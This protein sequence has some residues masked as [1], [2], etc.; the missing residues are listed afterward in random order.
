MEYRGVLKMSRRSTVL[1]K[2]VSELS[3]CIDRSQLPPCLGGYFMYC[4]PSWVAF[5]KEI[6]LFLQ[7][8]PVGGCQ[9]LPDCISTLQSISRLPIPDDL[10]LLTDFC[11][12]TD[13][14]PAAQ[15]V[16]RQ[17]CNPLTPW[18]LGLDA[19]QVRCEHVVS[20]LRF[21]EQDPCYLAMAGTALFTHTARDMLHNYS[22]IT[23]AVAK[24]ELLWQQAFSRAHVRL[25]LLQLQV[26]ALKMRDQMEEL[27]TERVQTYGVEAAEDEEKARA[28][29]A[30]FEVSVYTPAV[31]REPLLLLLL[32]LLLLDLVRSSGDVLHTLAE[33]VSADGGGPAQEPWVEEVEALAQKLLS[34]VEFLHRTLGAQCDFHHCY[35][36]ANRWYSLVLC[37][38]F[39]QGL[40]AGLKEESTTCQVLPD[41]RP[42]WRKPLA[43]FL[44]RN[45]P[46]ALEE[47]VALV[48]LASVQTQPRLQRAGRQVAQRC[49][50]LRKLLISQDAVAFS[51][52][53]M[54]L[55]WQYDLLRSSHVGPPQAQPPA[56]V[57]P[58]KSSEQLER[59]PSPYPSP[60]PRSAAESRCS[61][62]GP[63]PGHWRSQQ[64]VLLAMPPPTEGKPSSLSSFDSGFD[65]AGCSPL[66]V[67]G[68]SV[69]GG[70]REGW[71][72]QSV[73]SGSRESFGPPTRSPQ[74]H[75]D[76]LSVASDSEDLR[77]AFN[78]GSAGN[79][80]RASIQIVPKI[81]L[82]SLNFEI[83]V[84]RSATPPQ[85]PWLSLPV[86]DL[87]KSYTVTI[88]PNTPEPRL[89][90][91]HSSGS[92]DQP[93][94]TEAPAST[95]SDG[96]PHMEDWAPQSPP[97]LRDP[98]LSPIQGL[99]S[100]TITD[101]KDKSDCTTEGNP[102]LIWD[103][104][105]LHDQ[106][107][108][109][110][111]HHNDLEET[112]SG[113]LDVSM[114]DWD[115]K[116]QEDLRDVEEILER[117]DG[118]LTMSASELAEAGV[119][120]NLEP[121]QTPTPSTGTDP[122]VD[123]VYRAEDT[124]PAVFD[125]PAD[126][127]SLLPEL[128]NI[129]IL[130]ELILEENLKIRAL[131]RQEKTLAEEEKA[132]ASLQEKEKLSESDGSPVASEERQA[133]RHELQKEKME[134][135]RMEKS[136]R[137]ELDGGW[138]VRR[139]AIRIRKVVKCSALGKF[140]ALN[141]EDQEL[142]NELLSGSRRRSQKVLHQTLEEPHEEEW[143]ETETDA[144]PG[145]SD[146]TRSK[147]E[148]SLTPEK[149][150]DDGAFDPGG[151][152]L[153]PPPPPPPVPKPRMLCPENM[154]VS[155]ENTGLSPENTGL[156]S[157]NTGISPENMGISPEN[158]RLSLETQE[159][160]CSVEP[161]SEPSPPTQFHPPPCDPPPEAPP[162]K[163]RERESKSSADGDLLVCSTAVDHGSN[164]NNNNNA[165]AED[166][167]VFYREFPV[168]STEETTTTENA[169]MAPAWNGPSQDDSRPSLDESQTLVETSSSDP[170]SP[171]QEASDEPMASDPGERSYHREDLADGFQCYSTARISRTISPALQ[172][173]GTR[174]DFSEIS[175]FKTPIILDTGSGVMKAGFSDQE[176]PS[177]IFPTIIGL[178]KYEE[179]M[180][181][182]AQQEAYIGH[183]AQQMRGVLALRYPMKNG[184]I[185]NWDDMEKLLGVD[186]EDHPV[187]LTEAPMNPAESRARAVEVLFDRFGVPFV[188][189]A[190]QPVL[191]LYAAGRCTGV[192]FDSGDG[193]SH[194]VPVFEGY[195]L[196]HAIQ[197]FPLAGHDVTLHLRKEQ[198]VCLRT[199][200]ELEIVRE[201][202]ERCCRVALDYEAE[203]TSSTTGGAAGEMSYTLPDGQV[204]CLASE[205][206]R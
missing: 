108:P 121:C 24:V 138:R 20:K 63:G 101:G 117:A 86:D 115:L 59:N 166:S 43:A 145:G 132:R 14:L 143:L 164:N 65:G 64:Q 94:Q 174:D 90:R 36:K 184:V 194:S 88:T 12:T 130:D 182:S 4:H 93:T 33:T 176:L 2:D 99:L 110:Q 149:R 92:R 98:G 82:D 17:P 177:V 73:L 139:Q 34:R 48:Q 192:V 7:A 161:R 125:S 134:V 122:L 137:R 61:P 105:D 55:Q 116:V 172:P 38:N 196:P 133:F 31:V 157:E 10:R 197:R 191:A 69:S 200:A 102:T 162:P 60:R 135:E 96:G 103:S 58:D 169:T 89:S 156:S 54:A 100:S 39:L 112:S 195:S 188:Y 56:A 72:G 140:G 74:T 81:K 146:I 160:P 203:L 49:M 190:V 167:P 158:T 109:D 47:L 87:E 22:R 187:M 91:N 127:G 119:S 26:E 199:S 51:D 21:P 204:L 136:L 42:P 147:P 84:Q 52:L 131:Q 202:K 44:R 32:L 114:L 128:R 40:L 142:C 185:H 113:V 106:N 152:E 1:L 45:P 129:H 27:L 97:G 111:N 126:R 41:P 193:V 120:E 57:K 124:N 30:E 8:V 75:K 53:Q 173:T 175:D 35:N 29:A 50:T 71:R 198:G 11:S 66:E 201:M 67:G 151:D 159:R 153:S 144:E 150:P 62:T 85:N 179:M 18:E 206:F 78:F 186:P 123:N 76:N 9:R 70:G 83:K 3:N 154:G 15:K 23:A 205:R 104:Y 37:D 118:I 171:P 16:R 141:T 148:A 28:A 163:P 170:P 95:Q 68:C 180:N 181:G 13:T 165:L 189:V 107:H 178:P 77:E 183:N 19:L 6:D 155:P 25:R 46:P 5:I 79:S 168:F 80:S